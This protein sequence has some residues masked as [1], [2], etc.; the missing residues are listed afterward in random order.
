MSTW[1]GIGRGF[2]LNRHSR[3]SSNIL[4]ILARPAW[5]DDSREQC[6]NSQIA[7]FPVNQQPSPCV[8]W[9]T[10][11]HSKRLDVPHDTRIPAV[12]TSTASNPLRAI[13]S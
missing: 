13:M 5:F 8:I 10:H 1:T 9:S 3:H 6:G 12:R 11:D 4:F 2:T 7:P